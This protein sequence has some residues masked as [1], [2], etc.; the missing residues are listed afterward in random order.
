MQIQYLLL[1]VFSYASMFMARYTSQET[2]FII[3]ASYT[4]CVLIVIINAISG[5]PE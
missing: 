5:L 1:I 2:K 3:I 4:I